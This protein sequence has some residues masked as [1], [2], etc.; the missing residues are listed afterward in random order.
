MNSYVQAIRDNAES[1]LLEGG[2]LG[3]QIAEQNRGIYRRIIEKFLFTGDGWVSTAS[4]G[5]LIIKITAKNVTWVVS[6]TAKLQ[7]WIKTW[8]TRSN[9]QLFSAFYSPPPLNL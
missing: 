9:W 1:K 5:I 7:H 2:Y 8:I 3:F 6:N 4:G